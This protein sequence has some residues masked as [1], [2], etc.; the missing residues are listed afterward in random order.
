MRLCPVQ[1]LM[2]P[3]ITIYERGSRF[4]PVLPGA[5]HD[6]QPLLAKERTRKGLAPTSP[7]SPR[8]GP[9]AQ[10]PTPWAAG[11]SSLQA[12]AVRAGCP[13]HPLSH[14]M[15]PSWNDRPQGGVQGDKQPPW[16]RPTCPERTC[17]RDGDPHGP[18]PTPAEH[19]VVRGRHSEGKLR[20]MPTITITSI[21]IITITKNDNNIIAITITSIIIA[22]S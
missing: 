19:R 21:I 2:L 17:P 7:S 4:A 5:H 9:R 20:P 6:G 1:S 15:T 22:C 11:V 16:T 12:D 13:P 14:C 18:V 10:Q 8:M 3:T